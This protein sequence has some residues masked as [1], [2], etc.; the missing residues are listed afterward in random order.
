MSYPVM[1]TTVPWS[2]VKS[3]FHKAPDFSSLV[4]TPA[5]GRGRSSISLKPYATWNFELDLNMVQGGESV[6][7]SVLQSFLGC[8]MLCCGS[9]NF[10]TFTDPNDNTV[11]NAAGL[12]LNVTPG[13]ANPM[14]N[15][16]D[17]V[18]TQFQLAR[19]IGVGV[20]ILQNVSGVTLYVAGAVTAAS[21]SST[22]VVTFSTPP[23]NGAALTWAGNFTYL[24][25]FTDD[26]LKD[27]ARVSKNSSG[28]L[29]SCSSI[30]FE[31]VFV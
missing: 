4:Q 1:S 12:L 27:L 6:I 31:S 5:A 20:D 16:G 22:G 23:G 2:L 17:G 14:S 15:A 24:C 25:Q 21:I 26:T 30:D 11:T 3:G 10:F 18:S 9:G 7:G 13:A 19:N 28:F 29:W 8:F